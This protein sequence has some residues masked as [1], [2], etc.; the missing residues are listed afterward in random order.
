MHAAAHIRQFPHVLSGDWLVAAA[1]RES[2]WHVPKLSQ[3]HPRRCLNLLLAL[4]WWLRW[5]S[6]YDWFI[7]VTDGACDFHFL[8]YMDIVNWDF[9]S[10]VIVTRGLILCSFFFFRKSLLICH[11]GVVLLRF[12]FFANVGQLR[13]VNYTVKRYLHSNCK[14]VSSGSFFLRLSGYFWYIAMLHNNWEGTCC[15]GE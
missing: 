8:P 13:P 1:S 5:C 2:R 3:P 14:L 7:I 12:I 6:D 15:R 9:A 10:R 11:W 4:W